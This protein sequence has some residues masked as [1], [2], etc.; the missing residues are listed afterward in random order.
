MLLLKCNKILFL[1]AAHEMQSST[2]IFLDKV[3]WLNEE[4]LYSLT[5]FCLKDFVLPPI[6]KV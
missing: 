6:S 5:S 3:L 4:C 2:N 1:F